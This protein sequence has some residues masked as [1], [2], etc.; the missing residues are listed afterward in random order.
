MSKRK[1]LK[2]LTPEDLFLTDKASR[3]GNLNFAAELQKVFSLIKQWL[4]YF[5]IAAEASRRPAAHLGVDIAPIQRRSSSTDGAKA[6]HPAIKCVR[7][8]Q[9]MLL[10]VMPHLLGCFACPT[11]LCVPQ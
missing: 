3:L 2:G 10:M 8:R 5:D 6:C 11:S 7:K 9:L 4:R 1:K